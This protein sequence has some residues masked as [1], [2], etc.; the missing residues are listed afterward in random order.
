L[1]AKHFR[2]NY[3]L[4]LSMEKNSFYQQQLVQI[5]EWVRFSDTK[6]AFLTVIFG[7]LLSFIL[8]HFQDMTGVVNPYLKS[9][10]VF[11][12]I[13]SSAYTFY[14]LIKGVIPRIKNTSIIEPIFFFGF[15]ANQQQDKFISKMVELTDEQVMVALLEQIHV[16][17]S[18]AATKM[19]HA[20]CM[21]RWIIVM[22]IVCSITYFL[23]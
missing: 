18:I 9:W 3:F 21:S 14:N 19:N 22:V 6:I 5:N 17:S 11:L 7:W 16:N 13:L 20:K 2:C 23:K 10:L 1:W 12:A 4:T 8:M 15:I